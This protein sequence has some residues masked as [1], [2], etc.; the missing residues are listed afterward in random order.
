MYIYTYVF[1]YFL[2]LCLFLLYS[3]VVHW[4]R[5]ELPDS[6]LTEAWHEPPIFCGFFRNEYRKF[7]LKILQN[8][9]GCRISGIARSMCQIAGRW[10]VM[11]AIAWCRSLLGLD[12][13]DGI[14]R[15]WDCWDSA[16]GR[17][18]PGLM[19]GCGASQCPS[20]LRSF[21][22]GA[23]STVAVILIEQI[24]DSS[25][26]RNPGHP[27]LFIPARAPGIKKMACTT[28][29][30]PIAPLSISGWPWS[31]RSDPLGL[32]GRFIHRAAACLCKMNGAHGPLK[33][34]ENAKIL[35]NDAKWWESFGIGGVP[36]QTNPYLQFLPFSIY[37][38]CHCCRPVRSPVRRQHRRLHH[39]SRPCCCHHHHHRIIIE[40]NVEYRWI[41][42]I[43][44]R[45]IVVSNIRYFGQ[46]K[47]D[48]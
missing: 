31:W 27:G 26:Q 29:K 25:E 46:S 18:I 17:L 21:F 7:L 44:R 11:F 3:F 35:Q 6:S 22:E 19:D 4:K 36:F 1:Q 12:C 48:I 40:S 20:F 2:W 23:D 34:G 43:R 45:G 10:Y 39:H 32:L 13:K 38:P 9:T 8:H 47:K 42:T 5:V 28:T 16:D 30:S 14:K 37:L 41:I 15:T 33:W 24:F